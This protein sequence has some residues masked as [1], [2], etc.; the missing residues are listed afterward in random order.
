MSTHKIVLTVTALV[1]SAFL[2]GVADASA[3]GQQPPALAPP[4][5]PG[6][7]EPFQIRVDKAG[8]AIETDLQAA[9]EALDHLAVESVELRKTRVLT[10]IERP[11]H[12]KLFIFRARGHLQALNNDKADESYRELLRVDPFFSGSLPPREQETLDA[13][14]T[15]EGG[16]LEI[17]SRVKDCRILVDGIDVGVTGDSPVRV[18]LV[19][20][21]YEVRLEKPS[22]EAATARITVIAGQTVPVSDLAPKAQVPPLVFLTDRPAIGVLVDNV[23]VG[24]TIKV[25]ELK[26]RLSVEEA[27]ALDQTLAASRFDAATSAAIVLRDPPVDRSFSVRLRA[28]CFIEESRPVLISADALAAVQ[29][30]TALLW[31]GESQAVR[32]R[33]DTGTMRVTSTPTDA[34]VFLDGQ[35]SGRT[36][37]ERSVCSGEHKVRVRHPIGSYAVTAVITRG[38]TEVLDVALKPGLGFLGA[39]EPAGSGLR[40]SADA[41][42]AIDRALASTIRSFRLAAPVDIPAEV[43]RWTDAT[44]VDLV[45]AVDKGDADAVKRLLKQAREN[46]DAPLLLAAAVR[47]PAGSAD[48]PVELLLFWYEHAG[49]DRIRL[50]KAGADVLATALERIDRPVDPLQLV[51]RNDLGLRVADTLLPEASLVVVSVDAGSPAALAGV[52]AGDGIAAVDGSATTAAQLAEG[53]RQKKPG[54]VLTLKLAG[55]GT[56]SKQ[57]PVPV[58]RRPQHAPAFDPAAY[59]NSF[60]AKL[61][62]A[63]ATAK[64]ADKDLVNLSLALVHMRFKAWKTAAD[65]L[66][67]VPQLPAGTGTGPGAAAFYRAVCHLALGERDRALALLRDVSASTEVL[68]DDGA[69]VGTLA[70]LRLAS[71]GEAPKPAAVK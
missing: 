46:F 49:I 66:A 38:R 43:Q 9:L 8:Q 26:T 33:P 44:T 6:S 17:S 29:P 14:K 36:P 7:I 50:P 2:A 37:F 71:L 45:A 63:A 67:N 51:F 22:F 42:G 30:G 52:K 5:Q 65:L 68:A 20:G 62:V 57:I 55:G 54:E 69:A 23:P 34:D 47:G 48:A 18:S 1:V 11:V 10:A 53:V 19:S 4:V 70:K 15:R 59:G 21:A 39:V 31:L 41:T 32:M 61:Q 16:V 27:A 13:L 3:R 25:S 56:Q 64:G 35:L 58:Q 40:V 28:D 60:I 12:A 24:E